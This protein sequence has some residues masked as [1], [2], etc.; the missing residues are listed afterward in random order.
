MRLQFLRSYGDGTGDAAI[1]FPLLNLLVQRLKRL[2][3]GTVF[4]DAV[5]GI[6]E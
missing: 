5:D 1:R 6:R 2:F 4:I 3:N